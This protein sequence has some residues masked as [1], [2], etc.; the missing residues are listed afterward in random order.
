[1]RVRY[2]RGM[3]RSRNPAIPTDAESAE[4][5]VAPFR[6]LS[7]TA[8]FEAFAALMREMEA[9]LGDSEPVTHPDDRV[10]WRHWKDPSV[11]RSR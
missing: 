5:A 4:H 6:R 8:R 9:L 3:P 10:F 11:G 2:P 7:P 1:M